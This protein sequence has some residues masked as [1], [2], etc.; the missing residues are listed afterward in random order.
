VGLGGF[1]DYDG[2]LRFSLFRSRFF[3][4]DR[5]LFYYFDSM[6]ILVHSLFASF[7]SFFWGGASF[8]LAYTNFISPHISFALPNFSYELPYYLTL[9]LVSFSFPFQDTIISYTGDHENHI[10]YTFK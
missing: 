4:D 6:Y 3:F 7:L 9:F 10:Y 8:T 1:H 2:D 5:D